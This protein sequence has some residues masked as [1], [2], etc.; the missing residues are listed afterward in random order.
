MITEISST[1]EYQARVAQFDYDSAQ[2]LDVQES[3]VEDRDSV[4]IHAVHYA[5]VASGKIEAFLVIPR[6]AEKSPGV[7]WVHPAPGDRHTFL[8]EAVQLAQCGAVSLLIDAPWSRGEAWGRTMGEPEHD[9]AEHLRTV[10][11]LRRAID[12]LTAR[13]EVDAGRIAFVGHS[14]GALFG[15]ILAGV[16]KRVKTYVLMAGVASFTDIAV[17]NLPQLKGSALERYRQILEPIDPRYFVQYAAPSPLLFQF[18]LQDRLYLRDRF[19]EFAAAGSKPK[20]VKWYN[21]DHYLLDRSAHCDRA[22]WLR[23]HLDF[24]SPSG[25]RKSEG[26]SN[27][28]AN[29]VP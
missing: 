21:A 24:V 20:V 4:A 7:V 13:P 28:L 26:S 15:G 12:L 17:L 9:L 14:L 16:E 18:G 1:A 22:E 29:A 23:T 27:A 19:I 11:D 3:V 8:D 25:V 5:G 2:P 6:G 10:K